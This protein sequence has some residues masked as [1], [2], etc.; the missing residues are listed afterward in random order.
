MDKLLIRKLPKGKGLCDFGC[1]SVLVSGKNIIVWLLS[2]LRGKL[3][4][5]SSWKL[6]L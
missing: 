1:V 6:D 3:I 4:V 5:L 2:W